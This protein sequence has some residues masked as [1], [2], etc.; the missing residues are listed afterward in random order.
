MKKNMTNFFLLTL[1]I[2][3]IGTVGL[4]LLETIIGADVLFICAWVFVCGA[5]LWLVLNNNFKTK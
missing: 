1:L 2:S 5:G 4:A 3:V